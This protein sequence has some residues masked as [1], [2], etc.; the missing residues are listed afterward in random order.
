VIGWEGIFLD[1]AIPVHLGD[2]PAWGNFPVAIRKLSHGDNQLLF[3][4]FPS[5]IIT[6]SR[7]GL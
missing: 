7:V 5:E 3:G 4:R 2:I 6:Y 1:K